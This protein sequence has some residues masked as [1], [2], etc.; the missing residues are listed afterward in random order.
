MKRSKPAKK[1]VKKRA[2]R[3]P[4]YPNYPTWSTSRFFGFLRSALRSAYNRWPP[5]F[6]VLAK[7]RRPYEGNDKRTKWEFQCACCQ[8]WK[9]SS[10]VSVDHIVPAGSLN[11]FDDLAGFCQRLFCSEEDL[12]VLCNSCHKIKTQEDRL[13]KKAS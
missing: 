7:A 11:T 8:G 9:K 5:K 10:D 3:T 4:P 12:Q 2:P 13:D 1:A 6:Q